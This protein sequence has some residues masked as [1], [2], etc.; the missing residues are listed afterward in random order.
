MTPRPQSLAVVGVGFPNK[1]K[2][3]SRA[4]EI[5]ICRPGDPVELRPEP[6]NPADARAIAVFS[7]RDVQI[8]YLRAEHAW[9]IGKLAEAGHSATAIFQEATKY[10]AAIRVAFNGET[11]VLPDIPSEQEADSPTSFDEPADWYPDPEWP[12]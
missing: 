10:G 12:D 1:A 7:E 2:G 11:P 4:F 3:P 5:A 9:R 6:K 8:G